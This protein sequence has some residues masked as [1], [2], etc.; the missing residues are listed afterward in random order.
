MCCIDPLIRV[1]VKVRR[2]F[3]KG[4]ALAG[5][6]PKQTVAIIVINLLPILY[7]SVFQ[8]KNWTERW[9]N[10]WVEQAIGIFVA[11]GPLFTIVH[12]FLA[13]SI[14]SFLYNCCAGFCSSI[15]GM[16]KEKIQKCCCGEEIKEEIQEQIDE[17]LGISYLYSDHAIYTSDLSQEV[18]SIEETISV[19]DAR[20]IIG[21]HVILSKKRVYVTGFGDTCK[22]YHKYTRKGFVLIIDMEIHQIIETILLDKKPIKVDVTPDGERVCII[23]EG[24]S[25]GERYLSCFYPEKSLCS[26]E[27]VERVRL[28]EN[29]QDI[30]VFI[31]G[32]H[33]IACVTDGIAGTATFIDLE[34]HLVM[35]PAQDAHVGKGTILIGRVTFQQLR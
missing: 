9:T 22:C 28:G 6:Y 17:K 13:S 26:N 20:T 19:G 24:E 32:G 31:V 10:A 2:G 21:L 3:K 16:I 33:P 23:S 5:V 18:L 11:L 12:L 14:A 35:S 15:G 34:D 8:A 7:F 30:M 4:V 25:P 1:L 27:I 29:A